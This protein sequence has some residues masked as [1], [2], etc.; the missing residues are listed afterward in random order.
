M[1]R[2]LLSTSP[3]KSRLENDDIT[4]LNIQ[5]PVHK[6]KYAQRF[7]SWMVTLWVNNWLY[8]EKEHFM[9]AFYKPLF[10][11][12]ADNRKKKKTDIY[13]LIKNKNFVT[14]YDLWCCAAKFGLRKKWVMCKSWT[15]CTM[16]NYEEYC[17]LWAK[18]CALQHPPIA[19]LKQSVGHKQHG[20]GRWQCTEKLQF[21]EERHSE[22]N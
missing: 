9:S 15:V 7:W 19:M 22:G 17:R 20:G 16:S 8:L 5:V 2:R 21:K 10:T 18:L 11:K 14:E 1:Q 4:T 3:H 13:K 6:L 12:M